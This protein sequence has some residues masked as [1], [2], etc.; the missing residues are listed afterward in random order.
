MLSPSS[1][2]EAGELLKNRYRCLG[3]LSK[4]SYG[5]VYLAEDIV[6]GNQVAVKYIYPLPD[7][8]PDT[9]SEAQKEIDVYLALGSHPNIA[10]LVDY[11]GPYLVL[12]Y[13]QKGDLYDLIKA[14]QGPKTQAEI[15]D[16]MYQ[17]VDLVQYCHSKGVY[18]RDIKPENVFVT[19]DCQIKLGDWGLATTQRYLR[20]GDV[21]SDRYMAPELF[22]FK[23]DT[24]AEDHV[25]DAAAADIWAL[26]I[27][28]LNII[29]HKN[30]FSVA[31]SEDR[32]FVGYC[33]NREL[34]L[35]IFPTMGP[36]L[37]AVLRHAL[38][39]NP[40]HRD[41]AEV[42]RALDEVDTLVFDYE[43]PDE[44]PLEEEEPSA[45]T[46][47][48]SRPIDI[49]KSYKR[50][51]ERKPLSIQLGPIL[52]PRQKHFSRLD[53]Y[54]P[55]LK[56]LLDELKYRPFRRRRGLGNDF[57]RARNH[58]NKKIQQPKP[59]A[60]KP[61]AK[62]KPLTDRRNVENI[63]LDTRAIN[64]GSYIPPNLRNRLKSPAY[65][66]KTFTTAIYVGSP[67]VTLLDLHGEGS[68]GLYGGGSAVPPIEETLFEPL[69]DDLDG[70][71]LEEDF[72]DLDIG[73]GP[74]SVSSIL[75]ATEV[76]QSLNLSSL[77][78]NEGKSLE[79]EPYVPPHHRP[80]YDASKYRREEKHRRLRSFNFHG[81]CN[82]RKEEP[83]VLRQSLL[84]TSMPNRVV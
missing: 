35:D 43:V 69:F 75:H 7:A 25:Y 52:A 49:P 45:F 4:G 70:M 48:P 44:E 83:K 11:C 80:D 59:Q 81:K 67:L 57:Y 66:A 65:Q 8:D 61:A 63:R 21:G 24:A 53:L 64:S 12:E 23:N 31:L 46:T 30:P 22:D 33:S 32:M 10:A 47:A 13:C 38:A 16:V 37:F 20:D 68:F 51:Q 9:T 76:G 34:L 14:G 71:G 55:P 2:F 77:G 6:S 56:R 42:R 1:S 29:F 74:L 60:Q 79:Y 62:P 84:S 27:C 28:F 50:H 17:L 19:A 40:E 54:T 39:L 82:F 3:R 5:I 73:D 18:H 36:D 15:L 41:L 72:K 58:Q 26:G 78:T